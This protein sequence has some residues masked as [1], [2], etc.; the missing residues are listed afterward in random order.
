MSTYTLLKRE[1]INGLQ[2]RCWQCGSSFNRLAVVSALSICYMLSRAKNHFV[3]DSTKRIS[4]LRHTVIIAIWSANTTFLLHTSDDAFA[5]LFRP[6][7]KCCCCR[8]EIVWPK[9]DQNWCRAK[10]GYVINLLG[11]FS[12]WHKM[13]K[14]GIIQMQDAIHDGYISHGAAWGFQT[15]YD[16]AL[17]AAF[18]EMRRRRR[19]RILNCPRPRSFITVLGEAQTGRHSPDV[20]HFAVD[21]AKNCWYNCRRLYAGRERIV[22][23]QR[24]IVN[25]TGS[26]ACR[27]VVGN[28]ANQCC[29]P[30]DTPIHPVYLHELNIIKNNY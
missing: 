22:S 26:S 5:K 15:V 7:Y 25:A 16:T 21:N 30:S 20:Y 2:F 11:F 13:P 23:W 17:S 8:T 28:S 3:I 4:T 10:L 27:V 9:R 29:I 14:T 19:E 1:F 18:A 24:A 12:V 6:L